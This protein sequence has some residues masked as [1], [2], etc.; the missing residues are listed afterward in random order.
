MATHVFDGFRS[1]DNVAT[2]GQNGDTY[3]LDAGTNLN[4]I[5]GADVTIMAFGYNANIA[6]D[7]G[8]KD[9][10]YNEGTNTALS[11]MQNTNPTTIDFYG[12]MW[13]SRPTFEI[14][15]QSGAPVIPTVSPDG[16]LGTFIKDGNVTID[17]K[18]VGWVAPS[19]IITHT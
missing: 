5:S 7:Q 3:I 17:L 15:T 1:P 9:T 11:V 19:Q 12:G 13:W 16:N 10:I 8:G 18:Y 6:V 2:P 4:V 14:M